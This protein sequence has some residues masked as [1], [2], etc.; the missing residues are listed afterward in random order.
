MISYQPLVAINPSGLAAFHA[1]QLGGQLTQLGPSYIRFFYE[2]AFRL[3]E[4]FGWAALAEDTLVG[5]VFG[6]TLQER[7]AGRVLMKRPFQGIIEALKSAYLH[8]GPFAHAVSRALK[9][10]QP[11]EAQ[12]AELHFI[13]VHPE[14]RGQH[15]GQELLQRFAQ[16][17]ASRGCNQFT[18]SVAATNREAKTFYEKNAGRFIGNRIEAG[19]TMDRYRFEVKK[20]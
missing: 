16:A 9:T 1:Q 2:T 17:A 15:I 8:P 5:F 14:K 10:S 3:P 11:P 13:A 4:S 12:N 7:L 20:N 19:E 6:S 18:L